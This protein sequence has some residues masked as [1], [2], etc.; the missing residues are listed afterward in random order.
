MSKVP[1]RIGSEYLTV[2]LPRIGV[3]LHRDGKATREF[4]AL[5]DSGSTVNVAEFHLARALGLDEPLVRQGRRV[6]LKGL[7][8]SKEAPSNAEGFEMPVEVELG[9]GLET[10]GLPLRFET[11][12][13][14]TQAA[15]PFPVLL[16]QHDFLEQFVF[17]Q[18]NYAPRPEFVLD[19]P[20]KKR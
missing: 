11:A 7:G 13:Y 17:V 20:T 5:V 18:R 6:E 9:T 4:L 10:D 12:V 1:L 3:R 19:L 15:L 16:G 14:F 2:H 8:S